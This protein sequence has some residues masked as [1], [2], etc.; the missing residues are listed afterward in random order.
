MATTVVG[1]VLDR[2]KMPPDLQAHRVWV[3]E[4]E[5]D[6]D[7]RPIAYVT[8]KRRR[9]IGGSAA[10]VGFLV[11][12]ALGLAHLYYLA[13]VG[14]VVTAIGAGYGLG[15]RTG[16]YEVAEDGSLGKFIGRSRPD[17]I[18]SMRGMRVR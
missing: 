5:S 2:T 10:A 17:D 6:R 18:V 13:P 8:E 12:V 1:S 3:P 16:F 14:L 15:G 9:L 4:W 11:I 7:R